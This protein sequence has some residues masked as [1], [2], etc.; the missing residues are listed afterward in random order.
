MDKRRI[1]IGVAFSEFAVCQTV[2]SLN[3]IVILVEQILIRL[4]FAEYLREPAR[5]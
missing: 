1:R 4:L 5:S 3:T 2:K